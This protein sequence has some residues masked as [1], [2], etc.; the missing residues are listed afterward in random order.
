MPDQEDKTTRDAVQGVFSTMETRKVGTGTTL[1]KTKVKQYW[2]VHETGDG[3]AQVQP[4]NEHLIPTGK[5]R[6]ISLGT[7]LDRFNAEPDFYISTGIPA[8]PG[9]AGPPDENVLDL[10]DAPAPAA[11]RR[12]PGPEIE[13]FEL[14]GSAEEVEKSARASFGLGLTYLKRGNLSKAEDIFAKLA[15]AQAP[16]QPEH[17][18]MFNEFGMSLRKEK[19][20][21]TAV[22]H[23]M[24]ALSLAVGDDENLLHNIARAYFEQK[25]IPNAVRYLEKSLDTNPNLKESQQFLRYIRK[26]HKTDSAPISLS[27]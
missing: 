23:Y 8:P 26:K 15:E 10:D 25:D 17:K 1:R 4:I 11:A 22:K 21:D 6:S 12:A 3:L 19:L 20:L 9:E 14:S 24:R 2:L 18:H 13:G 5:K 27:F 16:F 7:L